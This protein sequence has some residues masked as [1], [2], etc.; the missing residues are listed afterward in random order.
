MVKVPEGNGDSPLARNQTRAVAIGSTIIGDQNPIAV[1]SMTATATTD[2]AAT[3]GQVNDL[4]AA[5]ADVVRIAVDSRRDAEA[6][7]SIKASTE[8]N[9]AVDLQENYRMAEIVAPAVDKIRYNP[10]HLY[11]RTRALRI[12]RPD[13]LHSLLRIPEGF[14]S[15][16]GDRAEPVVRRESA[17][18]STS[19]GGYRGRTPP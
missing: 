16:Q 15:G 12:T 19:P 11:Q 9:L 13:W 4:H 10:G 6:L 14:Q 17:R 8:A 2:I 5:G 18:D 7:A 3:A 1:Q